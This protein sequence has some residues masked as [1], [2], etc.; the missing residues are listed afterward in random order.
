MSFCSGEGQLEPGFL[1]VSSWLKTQQI[2]MINFLNIPKYYFCVSTRIR[3]DVSQYCLRYQ[4]NSTLKNVIYNRQFSFNFII[5]KGIALDF[6]YSE[7]DKESFSWLIVTVIIHRLAFYHVSDPV[8]RWLSNHLNEQMGTN[9]FQ[10]GR[11]PGTAIVAE[12]HVLQALWSSKS[13]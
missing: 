12:S 10:S 6:R 9:M 2:F 1:N 11:R 5:N 8:G 7:K 13:I 4:L 3:Q